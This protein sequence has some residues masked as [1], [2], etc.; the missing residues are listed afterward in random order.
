MAIFVNYESLS[1]A[2]GAGPPYYSRTTNMDKWRD[3]LPEI[4]IGDLIAIIISFLLIK[5]GIN[6]T[7]VQ[8]R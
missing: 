1:E 8:P 3:P 5:V 2:Y 4:M 7:K 6:K